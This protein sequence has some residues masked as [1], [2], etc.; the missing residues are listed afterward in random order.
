MLL[1]PLYSWGKQ[2]K[3]SKTALDSEVWVS[4]S[5]SRPFSL[6]CITLSDGVMGMTY[7]IKKKIHFWLTIYVALGKLLS[8]F[9]NNL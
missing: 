1:F 5:K 6:H 7:R 3:A 8:D 2:F 9:E 4:F